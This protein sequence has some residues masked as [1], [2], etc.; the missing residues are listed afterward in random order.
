MKESK[1]IP[2]RRFFRLK[3]TFDYAKSKRKDGKEMFIVAKTQ[4]RGRGRN[5]RSFSSKKGGLYFT[6]LHYPQNLSSKSAF[7]LIRQ[8]AV[9]VCKTIECY[10]VQPTIKWPND[11]L[12]GGKK[13][14]G[15]LTENTL[16]GDLISSS[17]VGIGINIHNLLEE[18]LRPI[19]TTLQEVIGKKI[20]VRDVEEKLKKNLLLPVAAEEYYARL[21]HLGKVEIIEGENRYSAYAEGVDEEGLLVVLVDGVRHKKSAAE[22]SLRQ[23]EKQ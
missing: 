20:P 8:A 5:E 7:L 21:S 22:I 10:G 16:R 11:V 13:V 6:W 3:S 4:S 15:I 18:D 17:V 23:K 1:T 12:V 19:A 9:A 2:T 14:S